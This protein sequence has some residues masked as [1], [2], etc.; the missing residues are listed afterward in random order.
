MRYLRPFEAMNAL[1]FHEEY[2][3][4]QITLLQFQ[5]G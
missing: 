4:R 2:D 3:P 5:H 1:E